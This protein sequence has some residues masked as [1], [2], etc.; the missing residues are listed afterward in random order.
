MKYWTWQIPEVYRAYL[1]ELG[2]E[3]HPLFED[4]RKTQY[5]ERGALP[6]AFEI[7]PDVFLWRNYG[8][9]MIYERLAEE[10][11]LLLVSIERA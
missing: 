1:T 3:E 5:V 11:I 6:Q 7:Y 10:G 9:R 2:M 4:F 8:H